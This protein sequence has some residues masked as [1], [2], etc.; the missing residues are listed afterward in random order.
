MSDMTDAI[1]ASL[2]T[3]GAHD[4]TAL[5]GLV[6]RKQVSPRELVV[7]ALSAVERLNP[8]LNAVCQVFA[9]EALGEAE[10]VSLGAP[11]AGVPFLIKDLTIQ[12]PGKRCD[13]GSRFAQGIVADHETELMRRFRRSG[14]ITIGKTTT[15]ELGAKVVTES[16]LTG[17]TRNPWS[18]A[19]TPGGSSG[20]SSAA[21]AAGIV[22]LAHGNDG[23]GSIRIPASNCNLF[24]LKPTRQRTPS[25]PRQ[26]ELSGGRAV[27]FVMSR[28]VRDSAVMLDCV[29]GIDAGAPHCA[30]TPDR[31]FAQAA[32]E[33]PPSLRIAFMTKTFSGA[34]VDPECG[35]A[36]LEAAKLCAGFG[37]Q[38]EEARLDVGWDSFYPAL[39]AGGCASA[40]AGIVMLG[41]ALART[42][43]P[44][45]LEPFTWL[46]YERGRQMSAV[47]YFQALAEFA[48]VQRV[49][50]TYF[51]TV[52]ILLTPVLTRPPA[53]VGEQSLPP[54]SVEEAWHDF[55]G[56]GYSPFAGLFNITGQPAA[57]IPFAM[58]KEGL[59]IGIHAVARFGDEAT[60]F[61]LASQI[62]SARP[63]HRRLPPLHASNCQ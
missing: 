58:S 5:A 6:R 48:R 51:A 4:A 37:H 24:G 1:P 31:P 43:S 12:M 7:A 3:Y 53:R 15:P 19:H 18:L 28:S 2:A 10:N 8:Q 47:D 27:E 20:G 34:R 22:P 61:S 30:P 50:G 60:I 36:V 25:G 33:A 11:F 32:A 57:S 59:P 45:N 29:H 9:E 17:Y 54:V 46:V 39:I 38:V 44:D 23:L 21:V 49:L 13:S 35:D 26:G 55:G 16:E 63:W 56:D 42:P 52:D 41:D 62:E 40:A 14:V